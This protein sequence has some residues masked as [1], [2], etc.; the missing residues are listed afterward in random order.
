[1]A[2]MENLKPPSHESKINF[3]R[4]NSYYENNLTFINPMSSKIRKYEAVYML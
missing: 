2:I 4:L 1:M 3:N